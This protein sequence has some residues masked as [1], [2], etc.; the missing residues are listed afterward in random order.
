MST[1]AVPG[2]VFSSS[3]TNAFPEPLW[4]KIDIR[5]TGV[6]ISEA[7]LKTLFQPFAQASRVPCC[8][9]AAHA[10]VR[11]CCRVH[12]SHATA[13]AYAHSADF[14]QGWCKEH[15]HWTRCA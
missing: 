5:D 4:V 3:D 2:S 7:S 12:Q 9:C 6:G 11:A 14:E 10:R 13:T 1:V 15:G 8:L